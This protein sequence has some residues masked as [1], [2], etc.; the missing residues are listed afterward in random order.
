[1]VSEGKIFLIG[2]WTKS[3]ILNRSSHAYWHTLQLMTP[4]GLRSKKGVLNYEADLLSRTTNMD[5]EWSLLPSVFDALLSVFDTPAIDMFASRINY[6][7]K[8]FFSWYPDPSSL[9]TD[10]F[11]VDWGGFYGY[12]FPPFRLLGH[13]IRKIVRDKATVLVVMPLWPTSPWFPV[14]LNLLIATP[15][16][17]SR[18]SLYLPQDPQRRHRLDHSL[19]MGALL[20]SGD[21]SQS[22]AFRRRLPIFS[23]A[24]G[25]KVRDDSIGR[26]WRDGLV[27]ATAGALVHF[28]PL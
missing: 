18:G 17:I 25:E 3:H 21:L 13:V 22:R 27:F 9:V 5:T 23:L 15:R 7:L 26:I 11:T 8:S 12:A 6:K 20:L 14:A 28:V 16:L 2:I 19:V 4:Q 24:P 10:A 1:M